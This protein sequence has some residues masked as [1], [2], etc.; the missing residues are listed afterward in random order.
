MTTEALQ[1]ALAAEHAALFVYGALGAQTSE[2]REPVVFAE[3]TDAYSTHRAWRDLL[4]RRVLEEGAEPAP[5]A[6]TYELPRTSSRVRE[7]I[8]AAA[9]LEDRCAE[10]YAYVV[11]NT[12]GADRHWAIEALIRSAVRQVAFGRTPGPFPGAA[13]LPAA[14]SGEAP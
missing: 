6:P 9:E 5:A 13:D 4:T 3:L 8:R 10:T 2:S 11:A 14:P 7:V 1:T 12:A